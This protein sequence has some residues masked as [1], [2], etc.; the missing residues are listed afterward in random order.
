MDYERWPY[1]PRDVAGSA[2]LPFPKRWRVTPSTPFSG[3]LTRANELT[4]LVPESVVIAWPHQ[5]HEH[6]TCWIAYGGKYDVPN[7]SSLRLRVVKY[8]NRA[9]NI[10]RIGHELADTGFTGH[11][12]WGT[13]G[14]LATRSGDAQWGTS[15]AVRVG[16][17]P[18][19]MSQVN[20]YRRA[21]W[22]EFPPG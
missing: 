9:T 20:I 3:P 6:L 7:G 8:Y 11:Y 5:A 16:F 13:V 4:W 15:W 12:A 19:W 1:S 21:L 14:M 2:S 22:T 17:Q 10:W 18:G